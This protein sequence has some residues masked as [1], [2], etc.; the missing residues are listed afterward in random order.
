MV[1]SFLADGPVI[2][3]ER[4]TGVILAGGGSTRFGGRAKGLEVI[5]AERIID[6]VASAL[7]QACDDLLLIAA[8]EDAHGWLPG[9]RV[10]GDVRPGLGPLGGLHG[11]LTHAGGAII[12][13]AWDMPFVPDELVARLRAEGEGA[14]FSAAAAR[15]DA[16]VPR[17]V[18]GTTEPLCAFYSASCLEP[19]ERALDRGARHCSAFHE[20]VLVRWLSEEYLPAGR[21]G[22]PALASINSRAELA[23]ARERVAAWGHRHPSPPGR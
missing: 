20:E 17:R 2:S 21:D 6:R 18:D 5:G 7:R 4:C 13:I 22:M 9:I 10:A 3:G 12:A 8:H 11:A 14:V 23:R 16:V 15:P 19:M 1:A